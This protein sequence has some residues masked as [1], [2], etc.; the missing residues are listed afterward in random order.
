VTTEHSIRSSGETTQ[1]SD[2]KYVPALDGVRGVAVLA[3]MGYHG[4]VFLT[5]GGFYSLD[6]FFALSGFLITSLLVAE[7]QQSSTIRLGRFWARRARRLLPALFLMLL[8]VS[9]Y[10]AFVAPP[11]MYPGFRGD[12]LSSLFYV[13]NWHFVLSGSNYFA[14]TAATSPLLHMWSLAVEEQF[15]LVWPLIVLLILHFRGSLRWLL[16]VCI[17]GALASAT[18]MALV[19]SPATQNRVYYGTDTRA[20]SLLV[21]AALAVGLTLLAERRKAAGKLAG[22]TSVTSSPGVWRTRDRTTARILSGVGLAGVVVSGVLWTTVNVNDAYAFTGCFLL[23]AIATSCVLANIVVAPR[24]LI[25][26]LLSFSP[27]RY[28]GQISY[29]VYLWHFPLFI[30]VDSARTGLSGF[31]LFGVRVACTLGIATVSYYAVEQPIRQRRFLTSWRV[32][33]AAPVTVVVIVIAV[34]AASASAGVAAPPATFHPPA[35]HTDGIY[36]GPPVKVLMVGD[37]TALTL[38]IGLSEYAADYNIQS[39]DAGIV[40][41]GVTDGAEFQLHGVDAPMSSYCTGGSSEQWQ[42]YWTDKIQRIRPNVV[43]ILVGRWEIVN[44]TYQGRWTNILQPAYAAYVQRQLTTAVQLAGSG[45][46]KVVLMTAPCFDTGEQPNGQPWPEDSPQRLA[47]YN[48]IARHVA[49]E[50]AN[51][52]LVNFEA[53]A[54]PSGHYQTYIDGVDARYDGVHFTFDGGVVFEPELYPLVE[55][56][57]RAQM[58][59][60]ANSRTTSAPS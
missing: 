45:G 19:H 30:Y 51:A 57:G 1:S 40:G 21:G 16:A 20:Q 59:E 49:A 44:R 4:G 27:L 53:L 8:A 50:F 56:L 31:A 23:A 15:Y 52:T 11:G 10:V 26:R 33:V 58:Q 32:W 13:A 39:Y 14:Q 36:A 43:M 37:S 38:G 12:A 2:P 55:R 25:P 9:A 24:T 6:T 60:V 34:V 47:K 5:N 29:G 54:C 22:S 48:S 42:Q 17:G 35:K 3:I 7:W 28:L 41:C 46:A 18:E